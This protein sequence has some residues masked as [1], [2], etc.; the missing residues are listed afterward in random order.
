VSRPENRR[1]L[2]DRVAVLR[3]RNYRLLF[4][5]TLGSGVGSWMATIALTADIDQQTDSTW[6][7]SGIFLVTFLPSVVVG[8]TAGPLVDRVSRK[9]LIVTSDLARLVVFAALPYVRSATDVLVLAAV[10]GVANSFFRPA[11]FAGM[12]NLVDEEE[13]AG[14]ASLLQAT[15]WLAASIGPLVGG[16]VVSAGGVDVVYWVNAATFLVSAILLVRIPAAL[17]HSEQGI[18]RGHW[19]DLREG[20]SLFRRSRVLQTVL[21]GFGFAMLAVGLINVSEIFLATRTFDSGAFGYGLLWS[22]TGVGLV[23]GS[24]LSGAILEAHETPGEYALVFVPWAVGTLAAAVSP[25][26]W[27]ASFAMMLAGVGN[28]L[29]FPMSV[30]LVQRA[31]ADR[32]R[33][34]AFAVVISAHNALFAIAMVA[35]AELT[36]S[37][38]ARWTYVVASGL[39]MCGGCTAWALLRGA[40]GH[41]A[42]ASEQAI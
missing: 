13:L 2:G 40:R 6:W 29:T 15:E 18:T 32:L 26:I 7:V 21:F 14:A 17:L 11:V 33:G 1:G 24:I 8:L 16:V 12:P 36:A 42:R 39:V 23:V 9:L 34:R 4:F 22:G 25:N 28:G 27:V 31:T 19:H 5:A 3:N 20:V 10:A 38:G 37:V 41:P 30:V 35:S